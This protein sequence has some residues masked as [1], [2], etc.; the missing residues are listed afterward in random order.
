MIHLYL[1]FHSVV[2]K[3]AFKNICTRELSPIKYTNENHRR[4]ILRVFVE[5]H[6][7]RLVKSTPSA[8]QG[9]CTFYFF[10]FSSMIWF[11]FYHT[12]VCFNSRKRF[13]L[14]HLGQEYGKRL[15]EISDRNVNTLVPPLVDRS[16]HDGKVPVFI[17][18]AVHR[19]IGLVSR[20][21]F[22]WGFG[23]EV[24]V[25]IHAGTEL[26]AQI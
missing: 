25:F 19:V 13:F 8:P 21:P 20:N 4:A 14:S 15:K 2:L 26:S 16:N 24:Q 12:S 18:F 5:R 6:T 7:R 23:A 11:S 3:F 22:F 10:P 1:N 17:S 9:L